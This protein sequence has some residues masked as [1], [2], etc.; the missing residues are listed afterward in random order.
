MIAAMMRIINVMSCNASQTSCRN[1]FGGFGGI[2][3]EPNTSRRFDRS[4]PSIPE[5]AQ[6]HSGLQWESFET[7]T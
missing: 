1:D 7:E 5:T 2:T 3:L 4:P 6:Q